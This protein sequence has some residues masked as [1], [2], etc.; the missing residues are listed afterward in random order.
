[1]NQHQRQVFPRLI[2]AHTQFTP[3][4]TTITLRNRN[5]QM[6]YLRPAIK[7]S[8]QSYLSSICTKAL[9][10]VVHL[11]RDTSVVLLEYQTVMFHHCLNLDAVRSIALFFA[12]ITYFISYQTG[13]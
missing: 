1:M 11:E 3:Y 6:S 7:A 4:N 5:S 12:R 9:H 8:F 10:K 13:R 2:R